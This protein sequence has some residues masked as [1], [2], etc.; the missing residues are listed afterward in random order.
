MKDETRKALTNRNSWIR[1]A[2][3]LLFYC[4]LLVVTPV[5]VVASLAGWVMLLVNG[6]VPSAVSDFGQN[7]ADWYAQTARY[8]TGNAHR[9]PFPFE[10]LDCPSDDLPVRGAGAARATPAEQPPA[11][12]VSKD[13][14][15]SAAATP[16]PVDKSGGKKAA[17]KKSARKKARKK[18]AKKKKAAGKKSAP[19]KASASGKASDGAGSKS[20][21]GTSDAVSDKEK[22]DDGR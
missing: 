4:L 20:L 15:G 18:T 16:D 10:D 11:P 2:T 3:L 17:K 5:L 9:R 13:R 12:S 19:K 6:R 22:V 21:K 14:P 1:G 8:I 7:V